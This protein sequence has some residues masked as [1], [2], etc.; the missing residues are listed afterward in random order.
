MLHPFV[1]KMKE[2]KL[3]YNSIFFISWNLRNQ[4]E[5]PLQKIPPK[6]IKYNI[7]NFIF[8]P[9]SSVFTATEWMMGKWF[10]EYRIWKLRKCTEN[11][12]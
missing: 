5:P 3:N 10:N 8:F 1:K 11:K 9:V 7:Q 2:L 6:K 12:I 4:K